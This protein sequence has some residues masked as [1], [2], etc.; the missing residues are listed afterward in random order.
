MVLDLSGSMDVAPDELREL[1]RV[2]PAA[3]VVGYSHRPGDTGVTPNAWILARRG[4]VVSSHPSGNVGNGVDGPVLRWAQGQRLGL[5][6]LVWVTDGQVTDSHDHPDDALTSEC[7][8]LV[9]RHRIRLAKDVGEARTLLRS[10]RATPSSR[11]P[12]FGRV[13]R[14]LRESAAI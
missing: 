12:E 7:A 3:L 9:R 13:G 11:W 6:P 10:N 14:E 1:L 8:M 2:A 5:E 4:R